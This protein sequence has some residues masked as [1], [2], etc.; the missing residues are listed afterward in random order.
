MMKIEDIVQ[1][2]P[3]RWPFLLIDKV[4]EVQEGKYAKGIKNVTYN[5]QFFVG[6]F[7]NTPVMPGV[8]IIEAMAQLCCVLAKKTLI[9][10]NKII[11]NEDAVYLVGLNDVKFKRQVIPGDVITLEAHLSKQKGILWKFD[12]VAMVSNEKAATATISAATAS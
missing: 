3:H 7:P 8:L 6:H 9:T 11:S 10:Q 1:F 12:T 4:I 2:V 5:E